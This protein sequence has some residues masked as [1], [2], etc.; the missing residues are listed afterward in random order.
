MPSARSLEEIPLAH[1]P[2]ARGRDEQDGGRGHAAGEH[3]VQH[4]GLEALGVG[5]DDDGGSDAL[6][7]SGAG[8][9]NRGVPTSGRAGRVGGAGALGNAGSEFSIPRS[10]AGERTYGE[11]A[12]G[13]DA[14]D[15]RH[16][17][18]GGFVG[19]RG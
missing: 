1:G 13:R 19:G 17:E 14:E 16:G 10:G 7:G 4:A 6:D 11:G 12:A 18:E 15:G 5:L 8:E 2:A 3:G 9:R